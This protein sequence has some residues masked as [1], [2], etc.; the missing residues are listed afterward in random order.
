MGCSLKILRKRSR[1]TRIYDV[2]VY[3]DM[4]R[5]AVVSAVLDVIVDELP[6]ADIDVIGSAL[7]PLEVAPAAQWS[8]NDEAITYRDGSVVPVGKVLQGEIGG[9]NDGYTYTI[10]I[11]YARNDDPGPHEATVQLRIRDVT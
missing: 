2:V 8:I 5:A 11:L 4:P 10:R 3:R 6:E 7:A 9:G 1:E